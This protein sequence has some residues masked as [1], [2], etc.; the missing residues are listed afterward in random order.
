[1]WRSSVEAGSGAFL[2]RVAPLEAPATQ[3][4]VSAVFVTLRYQQHDNKKF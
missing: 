4:R 1:M 2:M 3:A